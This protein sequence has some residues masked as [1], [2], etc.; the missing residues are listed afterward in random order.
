[1]VGV[2]AEEG[3][4][5]EEGDLLAERVAVPFTPA[6]AVAP[7]P[8]PPPPSPPPHTVGEGVSEG[9]MVVVVM[10]LV[11]EGEKVGPA[12]N[13]PPAPPPK[14]VGDTVVVRVALME[15]LPQEALGVEEV[16]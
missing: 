16:V 4:D 7:P 9:D 8:P 6:V 12:P 1:M 11:G 2:A 15:A 13:P 14:R 10:L 5:P 3:E